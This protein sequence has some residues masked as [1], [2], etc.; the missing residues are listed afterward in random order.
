MKSATRTLLLSLAIVFSLPSPAQIE[1]LELEFETPA[2]TTTEDTGASK[3]PK[4][5]AKAP[6]KPA[7]KEVTKAEPTES[8]PSDSTA[9]QARASEGSQSPLIDIEQEKEDQKTEA[10]TIC[11]TCARTNISDLK[12]VVNGVKR[13]NKIDTWKKNKRG[14]LQIPVEG[15]NVGPCGSFHYNPDG[16][17]SKKKKG[18][19]VDNYAAPVT[20][21]A[22]MSLLQKWKEKC[23]DSGDGCRVAWGDISHRD[24]KYFSGH[25]THTNG[26]CIDIRPFQKGSFVPT[27]LTYTSSKYSRTYTS[28]FIAMAK[29][30]GAT[31]VYFND[32]K[33]GGSPMSGH[34]NHIHLCFHNNKKVRK[35]CADYEYNSFVCGEM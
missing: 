23:P 27:P 12:D 10:G 32:K 19:V 26:N 21:C 24:R 1:G 2:A 35:T 33:S 16:W 4:K 7:V 6:A 29:Q 22:F 25:K 15:G 17:N 5:P 30:L 13:L 18:E 28:Q 14:L 34:S 31:Q 3:K 8:A 20:A 9:E 11:I